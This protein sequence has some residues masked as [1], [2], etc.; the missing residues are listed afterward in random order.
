MAFEIG[1]VMQHI[2]QTLSG[3][4]TLLGYVGYNQEVMVP[5]IY[6]NFAPTG[7]TYPFIVFDIL[8]SRYVNYIDAT[9]VALNGMFEVAIHD[10]RQDL[11]AVLEIAARIETL[12]NR[13]QDTDHPVIIGISSVGSKVETFFDDGRIIDVAGTRFKFWARTDV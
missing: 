12:L 11:S 10:N 4:S 1:N 9:K 13:S 5:N 8:A 3:D 7:Y 2:Y 6:N